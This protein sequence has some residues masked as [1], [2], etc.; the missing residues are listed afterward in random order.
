MLYRATPAEVFGKEPVQRKEPPGSGPP[1]DV[2]TA[3]KIRKLPSNGANRHE[4]EL[5]SMEGLGCVA[6]PMSFGD[7]GCTMGLWLFE[8]AG[9]RTMPIRAI[10]FEV[11]RHKSMRL[12]SAPG[13]NATR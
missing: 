12:L 10:L 11:A 13:A 9:S 3:A 6:G 8:V 4:V 5:N 2:K 1:G 7:D